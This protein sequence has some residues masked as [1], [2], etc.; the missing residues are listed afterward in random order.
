MLGSLQRLTEEFRLLLRI[1]RTFANPPQYHG[2]TRIGG[3]ISLLA[4]HHCVYVVYRLIHL[5]KGELS[6]KPERQIVVFLQSMLSKVRPTCKSTLVPS[7]MQTLGSL[8]TSASLRLGVW[9]LTSWGRP[10][11]WPGPE[12]RRIISGEGLPLRRP[13]ASAGGLLF[14]GP[15]TPPEEPPAEDLSSEVPAAAVACVAGHPASLLPCSCRSSQNLSQA[16]NCV[17]SVC[18]G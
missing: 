10:G 2:S 14:G 12:V 8:A 11:E 16:Q 13:G 15:C 17:C 1:A 18:M 4:L 7:Q 9:E 5:V 6:R 3:R